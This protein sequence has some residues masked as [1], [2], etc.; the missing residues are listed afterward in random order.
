[1]KCNFYAIYNDKGNHF[2]RIIRA[3]D[4]SLGPIQDWMMSERIISRLI[5]RWVQAQI[6]A[7]AVLCGENQKVNR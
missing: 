4:W 3:L 7:A 6:C 2:W 5:G 1:M